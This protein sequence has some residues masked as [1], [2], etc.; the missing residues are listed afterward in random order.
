MRTPDELDRLLDDV[1]APG[2]ADDWRNES[3]QSGLAAIR[4]RRRRELSVQAGAVIVMPFVLAVLIWTLG[5][6]RSFDRS[7]SAVATQPAATPVPE[8]FIPGTDIR[9]IS[10]EELFAL[11]PDRPLALIGPKGNQELVFL[12][13]VKTASRHVPN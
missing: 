6:N 9:I 13:E 1:L 11:F 10:D 5:I 3:L 2:T 4:R 7:P 12:D 8:Q